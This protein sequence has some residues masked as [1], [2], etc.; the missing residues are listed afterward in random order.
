MCEDFAP[1]FGDKKKLSVASRQQ[2]V[3]HFRY[4]QGI[5]FTKNNMTV[6]SIHL[7]SLTGPLRLSSVSPNKDKIQMPPF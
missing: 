6:V 4:H 5:L 7:T 2:T 3:S 1:K